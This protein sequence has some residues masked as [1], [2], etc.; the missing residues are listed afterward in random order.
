MKNCICLVFREPLECLFVSVCPLL[1]LSADSVDLLGDVCVL[2]QL[3]ILNLR[4][5]SKKGVGG[6]QILIVYVSAIVGRAPKLF[7]GVED[8]GRHSL[9]LIQ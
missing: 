7:A 9:E 3:L 8:C 6:G 1:K 4:P 2:Y 5:L